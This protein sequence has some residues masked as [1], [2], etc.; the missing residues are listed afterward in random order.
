MVQTTLSVAASVRKLLVGFTAPTQ[1][2]QTIV[3]G[4]RND[5]AQKM[6]LSKVD[7][8]QTALSIKMAD[9]RAKEMK[10]FSEYHLSAIA[11]KSPVTSQN[12][13]DT[14]QLSATSVEKLDIFCLLVDR[15]T[16]ERRYRL[17]KINKSK[18]NQG[19][20]KISQTQ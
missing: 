5:Q 15:R 8:L 2:G 18:R 17:A 14:R 16:R 10:A 1:L 7:L 9:A 19:R 11:A 6:I 4:I 3:C 13:A 12:C 20:D